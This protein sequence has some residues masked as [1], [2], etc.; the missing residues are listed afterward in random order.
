[1]NRYER[2]A[3]KIK[4]L[5]DYNLFDLQSRLHSCLSR[6]ANSSWSRKDLEQ[7]IFGDE[8]PLDDEDIENI[9]EKDGEI[10]QEVRDIQH[11][12]IDEFC[13]E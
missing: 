11:E 1:M 8:D 10:W 7:Y 9:I 5:A 13:E 3:K 4:K 2:I 6:A 12:I